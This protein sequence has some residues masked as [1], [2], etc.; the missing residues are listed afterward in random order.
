MAFFTFHTMCIAIYTRFEIQNKV[1]CLHALHSFATSCNFAIISSVFYKYHC[2]L[3]CATWLRCLACNCTKVP[4]ETWCII[5][6]SILLAVSH[7]IQ[8]PRNSEYNESTVSNWCHACV[9]WIASLDKWYMTL[10]SKGVV[11]T[12]D[13]RGPSSLGL[14]RSI[15]WLLM[16]WLL[17]SPGHQ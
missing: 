13:V 3:P 11:L 2:G 10:I 1:I 8:W 7:F 17:A 4:N 9:F 16:P 6:E 5:C 14:T 15:S 12:L